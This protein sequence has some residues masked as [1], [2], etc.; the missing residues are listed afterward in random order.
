MLYA[1]VNEKAT[2]PLVWEEVQD[3]HK[4][5]NRMTWGTQLILE[6]KMFATQFGHEY[7]AVLIRWEN[8]IPTAMHTQTNLPKR[9]RNILL[10]TDDPAQMKAAL[11]MLISEAE[12]EYKAQKISWVP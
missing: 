5:L 7:R 1:Q 6:K 11:L 8:E 9:I 10:E 4:Y 2:W 12:P 3:M